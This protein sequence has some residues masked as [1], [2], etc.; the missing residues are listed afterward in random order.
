MF[1]FFRSVH[2]DQPDAEVN[3]LP[4]LLHAAEN[5]TRFDEL[6]QAATR[7]A[8][9]LVRSDEH[10]QAVGLLDALVRE[11]ERPDRTRIFRDSA[12]QALRRAGAGETLQHLADL[13][14]HGG[15]ERE[16]ILAFF[17]FIGGDAVAVLESTLFRTADAELRSAVF[18]HVVR[19]EGASQRV[20][21]RA[22]ADPSPA[23]TRAILEL[24]SHPEVDHDVALRWIAEAAAHPDGAVRIDAA[25]HAASV[26]GR[27]G[28]RV[29]LD[30]LNN[31]R[32]PLVR[33]ATIQALGALNDAAAV[34]FLARVVGEGGDE[35]VQLAAIA[36]LG[37]IGSGEAL[38][39]L[40]SVV[41]KRALFAGKTLTRARSGA[42]A[43]IA[44]LQGPAAREVMQSLAGGKDG[45]VA[46]E[47]Q[48]LLATMG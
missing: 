42:L 30:L 11:A 34:P 35:E 26:G 39:T 27:G 32:D 5:P 41:N 2:S 3:E 19:M 45:P 20:M 24:V 33:K 31:D 1:H 28:L 16:S 21:A 38:P 15:Q 13:L 18:R 48:R 40:L 43:A 12:Q 14:H 4:A 23:R 36:A 6:A 10:A 44:R 8:L 29:L 46:A 9:R 7:A 37:R 22:M 17:H 25:R 47:A